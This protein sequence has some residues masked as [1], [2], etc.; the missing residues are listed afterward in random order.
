LVPNSF[1]V[2]RIKKTDIAYSQIF[3]IS[4]HPLPT[5]TKLLLGQTIAAECAVPP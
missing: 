1:D 5:L 4:C 2:L 3:T